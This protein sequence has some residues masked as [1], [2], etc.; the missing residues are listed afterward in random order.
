MSGEKQ[1]GVANAA[2]RIGRDL[3]LDIFKAWRR[4]LDCVDALILL[5]ITM[6]NVDGVLFSRKLRRRYGG[7]SPIAPDDLRQPISS[8]VIALSLGLPAQDVRS[9]ILSLAERDECEVTPRGMLI[10][11]H[12]LEATNRTAIVREVYKLLYRSYEDLKLTGFVAAIE[13]SAFERAEV[14]PVRNA[15]AHGAKYVLR[16]LDTLCRRLG[17]VRNALI[18]LEVMRRTGADREDQPA[19]AEPAAP[20]RIV[21]V[22]AALGL[23]PEAARRRIRG[24]TSLDLCERQGVGVVT[25]ARVHVEPWF[26]EVRQRNLDNLFQ[27]FAGLA[28]VGALADFD[29]SPSVATPVGRIV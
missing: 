10:S 7:V 5:V 15:A 4:D 25:P 12:Q 8:S 14:Q 17:D 29:A 9:R 21:E 19:P 2:M 20:A 24:L 13:V 22:A 26:A 27:L 11:Q 6:G 23:S 18:F 16:T 1:L 28:D 3:V